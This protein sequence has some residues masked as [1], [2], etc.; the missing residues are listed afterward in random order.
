MRSAAT[1]SILGMVAAVLTIIATAAVAWLSGWMSLLGS[2]VSANGGRVD[3]ESGQVIG[4]ATSWVF[5]VVVVAVLVFIVIVVLISSSVWGVDRHR[6]VAQAW[7][8]AYQDGETRPARVDRARRL[9][10]TRRG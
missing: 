10:R 8:L 2:V 5:S 3:A 4:T 9:F 7:L 1:A 6:A